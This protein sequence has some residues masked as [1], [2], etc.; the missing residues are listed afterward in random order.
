MVIDFLNERKND[1]S[2]QIK[3]LKKERDHLLKEIRESE[4]FLAL[5]KKEQV[6]PFSVFSPRRLDSP[7]IRQIEELEQKVTVL[8]EDA[9]ELQIKIHGIQKEYET[10]S[11]SYDEV[12]NLIKPEIL[13]TEEQVINVD[14]NLEPMADIVL[15]PEYPSDAFTDE[16]ISQLKDDFASDLRAVTFSDSN[17][18]GDRN[19]VTLET[20]I[21]D[22]L[23]QLHEIDELLPMDSM[24][25]KIEIKN[26]INQLLEL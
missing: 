2:S 6:E 7:K 18:N 22:V 11:S 15:D 3:D 16:G 21:P 19:L 4:K 8:K 10:V 20:L 9:K 25:A 1:L 13:P 23:R 14:P 12:S 17:P 5:L 24:R 26:L